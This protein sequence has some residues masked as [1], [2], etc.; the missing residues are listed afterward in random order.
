MKIAPPNPAPP[1]LPVPGPPLPPPNPPSPPIPA[2]RS[3]SSQYRLPRR[4][5]QVRRPAI[6]C[7]RSRCCGRQLPTPTKAPRATPVSKS[8][9]LPASPDLN[10]QEDPR[11]DRPL[12]QR[13]SHRLRQ[14]RRPLH[15]SRRASLRH[16][17]LPVP[18]FHL[19]SRRSRPPIRCRERSPLPC[20]PPPTTAIPSFRESV[21]QRQPADRHRSGRNEE[22]SCGP[23]AADRQQV[24][25]WSLDGQVVSNL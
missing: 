17:A 25:P 23:S 12:N 7:L 10:L 16:R 8:S 4:T 9:D 3:Q 19:K 1:P 14:S 15:R 5:H 24:G 20:P 11:P 13:S 6:R 18:R 21:R 2:P 22:N